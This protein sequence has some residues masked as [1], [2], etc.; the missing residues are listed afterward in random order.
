MFPFLSDFNL[1]PSNNRLKTILARFFFCTLNK[2][3]SKAVLILFFYKN[4]TSSIPGTGANT[5]L[6]FCRINNRNVLKMCVDR[7]SVYIKHLRG[8]IIHT[9]NI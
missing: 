5:F 4:S 9:F 2:K 7:Q 3:I 6:S 8:Y 1:T